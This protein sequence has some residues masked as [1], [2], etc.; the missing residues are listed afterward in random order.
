MMPHTAVLA[1][2]VVVFIEECIVLV[3]GTFDALLIICKFIYLCPYFVH[4]I[5]NILNVNCGLKIQCNVE[6]T[7]VELTFLVIFLNN[8]VY[9][10]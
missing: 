7:V 1:K 2:C 8:R 4:I 10:I 3:F 9:F 5:N 6:P